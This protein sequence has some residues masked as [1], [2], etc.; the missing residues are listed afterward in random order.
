MSIE[1]IVGGTKEE[2]A[3]RIAHRPRPNVQAIMLAPIASAAP[4]PEVFLFIHF[5]LILKYF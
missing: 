1:F 2:V 4:A 5:I 3:Y